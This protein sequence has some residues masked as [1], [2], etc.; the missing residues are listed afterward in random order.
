MYKTTNLVVHLKANHTDEYARFTELKTKQ[1]GEKELVKKGKTRIVSIGGL[2]K[3]LSMEV[4][5]E[6]NNGTS[7]IQL[8]KSYFAS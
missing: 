6:F 2:H 1:D 5:K 4:K 8:V 7:M 3:L